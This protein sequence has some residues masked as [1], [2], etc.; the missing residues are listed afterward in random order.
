MLPGL[1]IYD[2]P[3]QLF[4]FDPVTGRSVWIIQEG[5]KIH[6]RTDYP[7]E[8]L[9][10]DNAEARVQSAGNRF[11]EIAR[12]ASIPTNIYYASGLQKAHRE[13]DDA[14]VRRWLNDSD[15]AAWRTKEG[16]V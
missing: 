12:V 3:W 2:G 10:K 15:N 16:R 6:V 14:F 1:A 11:G 4:D 13:G 5:G 7:H 9:I 8:T